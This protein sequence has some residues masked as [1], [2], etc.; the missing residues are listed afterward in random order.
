MGIMGIGG[1]LIADLLGIQKKTRHMP[2]HVPVR[3]NTSADNRLVEGMLLHCPAVEWRLPCGRYALRDAGDTRI[4]MR[5]KPIVVRLST[6]QKR[7]S[8]L[9]AQH[10]TV[11]VTGQL[12]G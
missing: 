4:H 9:R 11:F 8:R 3:A 7:N 1:A 5:A 12:G 2:A 6:S 10:A